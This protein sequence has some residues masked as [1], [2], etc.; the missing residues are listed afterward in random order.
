MKDDL[1]KIYDANKEWIKFADTKAIAFIAIIGFIFNI[2]YSI[3]DD[4]ICLKNTN[5]VKILF[6]LG[7]VFLLISLILSITALFPRFSKA[8]KNFIYYKSVSDNFDNEEYYYNEIIKSK[9]ILDKQLSYQNYQL[10]VLATKKY[11]IVKWVLITF[12]I[13]FVLSVVC[14]F[15]FKIG[16]F[17]EIQL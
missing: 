6:I 3:S 13:G 11:S 10:A 15:L 9:N 4:L 2:F 5:V 14:V 16:W 8:D 12:V 1:W 17:F 7:V